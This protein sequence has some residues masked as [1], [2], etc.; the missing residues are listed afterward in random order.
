VINS[1]LIEI[2]ASRKDVKVFR[3]PVTGLADGLGDTRVQSMVAVGA[4]SA[5]TGLF[6]PAEINR[7]LPVLFEGKSEKVLKMNEA[8]VKAGYDY[9]KEHCGS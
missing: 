4:F 6:E 9:V 2:D 8:A 7:L 5:I 3:V 1:T